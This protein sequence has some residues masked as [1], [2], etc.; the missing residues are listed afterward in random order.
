MTTSIDATAEGK[1]TAHRNATTER[2][3]PTQYPAGT[4]SGLR[5][6]LSTVPW[7]TVL[8]LAALMAYADG[9]WVTSLRGAV[10]AIERTQDPFQSWF[11]ES[12]LV[13]PVFVFAVLG[14]LTLAAHWFGPVLRTWKT[15]VKAVLL[16]VAAGTLVGIALLAASSAYDLHLQSSLMQAMDSM[17]HDCVGGDC[18]A[19]QDQAS[20]RLQVRSVTFGSGFILVTNLALVA[21]AVAMRGGRLKVSTT[22]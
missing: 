15:V 16:T 8:T 11:L 1:A 21:W 2:T 6:R 12:T 3:A 22:R 18:S 5:D 20:F 9:F 19:Q 13:L 7:W 10:G 4:R 14:A 17:S